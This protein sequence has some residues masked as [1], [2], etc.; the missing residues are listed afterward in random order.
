MQRR[1][2]NC[3]LVTGATSGIGQAIAKALLDEGS[4][5]LLNYCN[6]GMR[7][8]DVRA[9]FEK[10]NGQFS[11]I[12]ADLSDYSGIDKIATAIHNQGILIK[13]LVLNFGMTDRTAFGKIT[14]GSWERVMRANINIPFFMIQTLC[15]NGLFEKSASIVCISSLMASIPHADSVSYGVS[16]SALSA[17]PGNLAKYLS[18]M[19]IRINALEPGFV[20]TRWQRDKPPDQKARIE[21]K[22]ALG[23]MGEPSEIAE[24]CSAVLKNTYLTGSV[25]SISGGYGM[26]KEGH[27]EKNNHI[28]DV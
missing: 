24:M 9:Q 20:N 17:L 2:M 3:A 6:S 18:S 26:S 25:I 19:D 28:R 27:C 16:K 23:R 15:N 10:Y 4:Y 5:V 21:A 7:A 22:V 1:R 8:D 14:L 11:F 12:Q 13:Y